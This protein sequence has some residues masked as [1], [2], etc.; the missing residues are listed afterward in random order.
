MKWIDYKGLFLNIFPEQSVSEQSDTLKMIGRREW[1]RLDE[2]N[3]GWIDA[4]I[5]TGGRTSVLHVSGVRTYHESGNR[6]VE[7][8]VGRDEDDNNSGIVCHA[9]V[10]DQKEFKGPDG[11][12]ELKWIIRSPLS[13]G[14]S[15]WTIPVALTSEKFVHSRL[16]LG[17]TA[18]QG[19]FR[20]D[21]SKAYLMDKGSS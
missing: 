14:D 7:F 21:A 3:S 2:L 20:V 8:V 9:T 12:S 6:Q 4:R 5:A 16:V 18:L 13:L 10:Y 11:F 19:R 17:R 1:C 15:T